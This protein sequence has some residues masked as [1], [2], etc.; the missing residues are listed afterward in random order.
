M[1]LQ[2]LQAQAKI[3]V[4]DRQAEWFMCRLSLSGQ[5]AYIFFS[6]VVLLMTISMFVMHALVP[7]LYR[8]GADRC[9]AQHLSA[10][11]LRQSLTSIMS[12]GY[13]PVVVN[14]RD[15]CTPTVIPLA[16]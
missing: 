13:Q 12:A 10:L 9:K 5:I 2:S 6:E 14:T 11:V 4:L 7:G 8:V 16:N 15:S 1:K 3:V